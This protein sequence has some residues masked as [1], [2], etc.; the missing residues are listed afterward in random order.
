MKIKVKQKKGTYTSMVPGLIA[1]SLF[2]LI[3]GG[4][5]FGSLFELF[6]DFTFD[7]FIIVFSEGGIVPFFGLAFF[8]IS[9]YLLFFLFKGP[10]LY[11]AVLKN[12]NIGDNKG[13]AT[14]NYEFEL[15]G[16]ND[17]VYKTYKCYTDED[18]YL[19][20]DNTYG[21]RIKEFN[22]KVKTIE[23]IDEKTEVVNNEKGTETAGL[24]VVCYVFFLIFGGE[25]AFIIIKI[26]YDFINGN[27]EFFFNI[28]GIMFCLLFFSPALYLWLEERYSSKSLKLKIEFDKARI[29]K[30]L[31]RLDKV[32]NL[33][34]KIQYNGAANIDLRKVTSFIAGRAPFNDQ[35]NYEVKD[36][37]S[38][39]KLYKVV[40]DKKKYYLYDSIDCVVAE[41]KIYK[42]SRGVD[43]LFVPVNG[44]SYAIYFKDVEDYG[45]KIVGKDYEINRVE[46][47]LVLSDS[48]GVNIGKM[49][50]E[51]KLT[52][53]SV[54]VEINNMANNE[55]II[56]LC[57]GVVMIEYHYNKSKM[58]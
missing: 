11:V 19:K 16:K 39:E 42:N 32:N 28:S 10:K 7:N 33:S 14:Y 50:E 21:L 27:H 47:S 18:Y 35:D 2:F 54:N 5:L 22:W 40:N 44:N 26:I 24:S 48:S 1:T 46:K 58:L 13:K 30:K 55:D 17:S 37:H 29:S 34:S 3:G 25:L 57:L 8:L 52:F 20:I 36:N 15:K 38:E 31:R 51:N 43:V 41:I 12:I 56:M 4:M 9:L 6:K 53:L 23:E 49:Q 45:F